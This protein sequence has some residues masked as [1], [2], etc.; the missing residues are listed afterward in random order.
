M[1]AARWGTASGVFRRKGKGVGREGLGRKKK[2]K[3][4]ARKGKLIYENKIKTTKGGNMI[5]VYM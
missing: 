3:E 1:H 5:Q 2:V 4:E